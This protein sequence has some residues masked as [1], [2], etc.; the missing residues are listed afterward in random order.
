MASLRP[1]SQPP[2]TPRSPR[3]GF[4]LLITITLLAFLV[5]L[6]VSLASLTRV[7]TQVASNSQRLSSA[8]QNALMALNVALGQLQKYAGPDQR[9]TTT[10]DLVA[11]TDKAGTAAPA[12]LHTT[13]T[14]LAVAKGARFW[15]AVWGNNETDIRYD[16]RPD[17][18]P[19]V[20]GNRRGMTPGL[21]NWLVSGN[22]AAAFTPKGTE[23]G[24]NP[25][26]GITYTPDLAIDLS[27]LDAP[28]INQK[29]AVLLVGSRSVGSGATAQEDFVAAPLVNIESPASLVPGADASS[30]APVRVGRY[31][32]WVGDEGV[33]ARLNLQNGYQ[34]TGQ[35]SDQLN[36]FLT[37]QRSAVEFMDNDPAGTPSPTRIGTDFDFTSS[38]V[39][40]LLSS[41]QLPLANSAAP[42]QTRLATAAQNRFHDLTTQSFGVLA[43]TY[44]GGLKKD[45]TADIADASSASGYRPADNTP[46]FT[47][48]NANE[49]NLP[50]W[51]L[52]RN[53]ARTHPAGS[54]AAVPPSRNGAYPTIAYFSLGFDYYID[55]GGVFKMAF[56]PIIALHNPYTV[57]IDAADYEVGLQV[58]DKCKFTVQ[59]DPEGDTAYTYNDQAVVNLNTLTISP[60]GSAGTASPT[61]IR[62]RLQGRLIPPGQR[63]IYILPDALRGTSYDHANPPQLERASSSSGIGTVN[64]FALNGTPLDMTGVNTSSRIRL[65]ADLLSTTDNLTL[66]NVSLLLAEQGALA[67][68]VWNPTST[69]IYQGM[70]GVYPFVNTSYISFAATPG[71]VPGSGFYCAETAP[72]N[73]LFNKLVPPQFATSSIR[74]ATPYEG[75]GWYSS[76][77]RAGFFN[78]YI[79]RPFAAG[80]LRAPIIMATAIENSDN[81]PNGFARGSNQRLGAGIFGAVLAPSFK[82]N[83]RD[84]HP[85]ITTHLYTSGFGSSPDSDANPPPAILWDILDSPDRLLSL[86]QLQHV[87]FSR[88]DFQ[89]S[90]LFGNSYA[91]KRIRRDATYLAG[92]VRRLD[93]S[94]TM[95][96]IYDASWHLTR[97]L[98]DRYFVS[99]VPATWTQAD[100]TAGKPFPN[101]R[102][103]T[104]SRTGAATDLAAI[105]YGGGTNRAYDEA[106]ANLMVAGSFNINSTSEQAWRAV[107]ASTYRIPLNADYANSGDSVETSIPYP[108]FTRNLAQPGDAVYPAKPVSMKPY[109]AMSASDNFSQVQTKIRNTLYF[110]N[111]GLFLNAEN[112]S[113]PENGSAEMVVAELARS[114]VKEIRLRGPFLSLSDFINRPLT[115]PSFPVPSNPPAGATPD[116]KKIA[117]IKGALQAG[118]DNMNP[119]VAQVNP[120]TFS[121]KTGAL[122]TGTAYPYYD[123]DCEHGA[124]GV[125][126]GYSGILAAQQ[127]DQAY[128][129]VFALAPKYL[130]QADL[131]STLG[132]LLSP[133]SDT[134]TIRAYGEKTNPVTLET[135]GRAWCEAVVQ[136]TPDYVDATQSATALPAGINLNLGR[137][138]RVVSF[139]WLTAQE[140]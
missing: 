126:S 114:I 60:V 97:A 6:L 13:T 45:L 28:T 106:A 89:P 137:R 121:Q 12:A 61:F 66:T 56:Y 109:P 82:E 37:A 95:D 107:L 10:A 41:A 27:N 91:E 73:L 9:V 18:I 21:L 65:R 36:S 130:T 58:N 128:R 70:H 134:F 16:L 112:N 133:R 110:G 79:S 99:G 72:G 81:L 127:A 88:Y 77:W 85:G 57:P 49:A 76:H 17:T 46:V 19:P 108:R 86:G 120:I 50:T 71:A 67:G 129:A 111:R 34:K 63:H 139:R 116:P 39:P 4:A 92:K 118:I 53:W 122:R 14:R 136:R 132:P 101:A 1:F 51:G 2:T 5:L 35:T 119:A 117:G 32:W 59:V 80:T 78:G 43:D 11:S 105:Q 55:A 44:A 62:L 103:T 68:T 140:I 75:E 30:S 24:A 64:F 83:G 26:T 74:I 25:G 90:Y 22:E 96:P 123:W 33:K 125:I 38:T 98:W 48:V 100:V 115:A 8:Q 47:P 69:R 102:I 40:K 113:I 15:T 29:P 31:A 52:I 87:P 54:G 3:R 84:P 131:L 20:A 94:A 104:Y 7:E 23:G 42:A 93:G 124:G 135:E 138:F